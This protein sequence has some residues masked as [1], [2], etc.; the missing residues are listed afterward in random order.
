MDTSLP[1]PPFIEVLGVVNFRDIGGYPIASQPGKVVRQGLIFRSGNPSEV[2]EAG[3]AKLQELGIRRVYDLRSIP[4]IESLGSRTPGP[5]I[6]EW[7]GAERIFVPVFRDEDYSPE[8]IALR[9]KNYG[10]GPQGFAEA[11]MAILEAGSSPSN[12]YRPF[13]TILSQLASESPPAPML[14][15]CSAGKDR[16]GIVCALILSL[17][18]VED[19]VV[20]QEYSLTN[21]GLATLHDIILNNLMKEPIYRDHPEWAFHML[22]AQ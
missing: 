7:E 21:L 10:N 3:I 1:T 5:M 13:A 22:Q 8:A 16:T 14:I 19:E 9:T 4:E 18:G 12:A 6:K 20:A 17:C 2:W 11:Y 15:H